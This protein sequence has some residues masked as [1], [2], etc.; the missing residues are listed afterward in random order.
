MERNKQN[1]INKLLQSVGEILRT[2][3]Y[4]GLGVNRIAKHAGLD[5]KL[6]YIYFG[7]LNGLVSHYLC[8][9]DYWIN[10][11]RMNRKSMMESKFSTR[12]K[13]MEFYLEKQ[14]MTLLNNKLQQAIV[15]WDIYSDQNERLPLN[16][17]ETQREE[18]FSD[19]FTL[20]NLKNNSS[21][22]NYRA[23]LTILIS[24]INY[25]GIR[26]NVSTTTFCEIDLKDEFSQA[27][28]IKT[29][30]MIST[31]ALESGM[32]SPES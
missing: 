7:D 2:E 13:I 18:T 24:A 27:E 30:K 11:M 19:I 8:S 10:F 12:K 26:A 23:V 31:W 5:K 25:L 15:K 22:L 4:E 6:I 1:S 3:G 21:E 28:I 17:L 9:N 16:S 32:E 14:F 29:I 20:L